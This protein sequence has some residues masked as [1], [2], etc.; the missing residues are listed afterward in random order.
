MYDRRYLPDK[1]VSKGQK[2]KNDTGGEGECYLMIP[3]LLHVF[4]RGKCV[5]IGG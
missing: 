1:Q 3:T 5:M 4:F 2:M